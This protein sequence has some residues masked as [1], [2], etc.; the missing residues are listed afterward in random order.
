MKKLLIL[1]VCLFFG[2][3]N[4]GGVFADTTQSGKALPPVVAQACGQANTVIM[5]M[6]LDF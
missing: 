6:S 4:A 5:W 1:F 2:I 3:V